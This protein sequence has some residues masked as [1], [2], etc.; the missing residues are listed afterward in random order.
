M[1]LEIT[2]MELWS[3]F[4]SKYLVSLSS[5]VYAVDC[6]EKYLASA[7]PCLPLNSSLKWKHNQ[8]TGLK[9]YSD[10]HLIHFLT[11]CF[12]YVITI[13]EI[14]RSKGDSWETLSISLFRLLFQVTVISLQQSS[15]SFFNANAYLMLWF[16]C[17]SLLTLSGNWCQRSKVLKELSYG[18]LMRI[19]EKLDLASSKITSTSC[20]INKNLGKNINTGSPVYHSR[21]H[22]SLWILKKIIENFCI[23]LSFWYQLLVSMA[24]GIRKDYKRNYLITK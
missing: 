19:Q 17:S 16:Y 18:P 7:I 9:S 8:Y 12:R 3:I 5:K 20:V 11:I 24:L 15:R 23:N 6:F 21:S 22:W 13:C 2:S 14:N 1:C 4:I 10:L